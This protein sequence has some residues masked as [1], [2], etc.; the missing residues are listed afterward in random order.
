MLQANMSI[1]GGK[2]KGL[3]R[4]YSM[5]QMTGDDSQSQDMHTLLAPQSRY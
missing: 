3:K 5:R 4:P 2:T 1:R